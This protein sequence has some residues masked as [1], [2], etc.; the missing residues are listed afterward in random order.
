MVKLRHLKKIMFLPSVLAL[1]DERRDHSDE[2]KNE[3]DF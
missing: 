2:S 3:L 1:P